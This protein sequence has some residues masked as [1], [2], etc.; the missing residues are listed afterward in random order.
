[1]KVWGLESM[2]QF[3]DMVADCRSVLVVAFGGLLGNIGMEAGFVE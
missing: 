2:T 1:M 3:M